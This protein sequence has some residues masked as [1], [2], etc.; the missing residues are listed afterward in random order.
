MRTALNAVQKRTANDAVLADAE[1]WNEEQKFLEDL[2]GLLWGQSWPN[3]ASWATIARD[4][5]VSPATISKFAIGETKRPTVFTVR[6]IAL[7]FGYRMTFV[8]DKR[9]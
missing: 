5:G 3:G 8:K 4:A 9:K 6:K 2:R 1:R 7:Y